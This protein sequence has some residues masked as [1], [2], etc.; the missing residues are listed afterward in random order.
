MKNAFLA[1]LVGLSLMGSVIAADKPET[2]AKAEVQPLKPLT[3]GY[4]FD[5]PEILHRQRLFGLAHG[6]HLLASACLGKPQ[7]EGEVQKSYELWNAHQAATMAG[8][9]SDLARFY[10]GKRAKEAAW[11]DVAAALG[12][13][14]TIHPSLGN[15]S[16]DD[17]CGSF[18]VALGQDRY[19]LKAQMKD[20]EPLPSR[21]TIPT[22][23]TKAKAQ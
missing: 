16:L 10:F 1:L 5:L 21:A 2:P 18:A 11:A 17:A 13:K 20:V 22:P 12:L 6:V 3:Q 7:Y 19:D 4:A 14:E 23:P 15:V 9:R 8:L